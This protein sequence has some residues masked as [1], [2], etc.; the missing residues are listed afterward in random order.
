[1]VSFGSLLV[2][3]VPPILTMI[4]VFWYYFRNEGEDADEAISVDRNH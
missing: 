1:M 2:I 4:Y 3:F